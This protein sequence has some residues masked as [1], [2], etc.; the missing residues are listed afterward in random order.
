MGALLHMEGDRGV[1]IRVE[2]ILLSAAWDSQLE[3]R[4][5]FKFLLCH[6]LPETSNIICVCCLYN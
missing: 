4:L 1:Q 2:M 6:R 3:L 5:Q